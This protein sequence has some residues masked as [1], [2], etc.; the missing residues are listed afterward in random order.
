MNY[1]RTFKILESLHIQCCTLN[2]QITIQK[3]L[4]KVT[5]L[6]QPLACSVLQLKSLFF[7]ILDRVAYRVHQSCPVSGPSLIFLKDFKT[8]IFQRLFRDET[9][10]T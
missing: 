9:E 6:I 4:V 8:D 3:F 10:K 7:Q 2:T 5:F 1:G